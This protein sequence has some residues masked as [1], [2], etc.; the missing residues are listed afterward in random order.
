MA[1]SAVIG[2]LRVDLGIDSAKFSSGLER[3]RGNLINF[4]SANDNLARSL[5]IS[6]RA[7]TTMRLAAVGVA[8]AVGAVLVAATRKFAAETGE[9][10]KVQAQLAARLASTGAVAGQTIDSLN[11]NA[12][13]LQKITTYGDEAIGTSQALLLTFTN[14]RGPVFERATKAILDM[15]T[16]LEQDLKSSTIQLGKAL[17]DPIKGITALTKVGVTFTDAQKTMVESMVEAGET[18]KAQALILKEIE[19]QMGGAA[20]AARNT[21]PGA[22]DAL[23]NSWGNVFE[24]ADDKTSK[25]TDTIN[26][27]TE[28]I[29]SPA[30]IEFVNIIGVTLVG[31]LAKAVEWA[32]KLFNALSAIPGAL[33]DAG[34]A[35]ANLPGSKAISGFLNGSNSFKNRE[36]KDLD[37]YI[38][39]SQGRLAKARAGGNSRSVLL[40]ERELN[41][42]LAERKK[43]TDMIAGAGSLSSVGKVP[44][45]G[46]ILTTGMPSFSGGIA[47]TGLNKGSGSRVV[48]DASEDIQEIASESLEVLTSV[49]NELKQ[50]FGSDV[51]NSWFWNPDGL[52]GEL[53]G[54]TSGFEE[55]GDS[56]K[57]AADIISNGL[58]RAIT[59]G[60]GFK[61]TLISI[62]KELLAL[63]FRKSVL[64]PMSNGLSSLIGSALGSFGGFRAAGGPVSAGSAYVVGERGPELFMPRSNGQI[65]PN[66]GGGVHVTVGVSADNNGNILPF[67]ESVT[68]RSLTRA[69]PQIVAASVRQVDRNFGSMSVKAQRQ[70]L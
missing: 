59:S 14:I 49:G 8:V 12:S 17:N 13:A 40:E 33:R 68:Q 7:L 18:G 22:L 32:V 28:I 44:Q 24:V 37:R 67:V 51:A 34:N 63:S 66:G 42:L 55:I 65:V 29:Q 11:K 56:A 50:D 43:I 26:G 1:N 2:A 31:A 54:L 4:K 5:G 46:N 58:E 3:A 52:G 45:I 21:L 25:L 9:A 23:K 10:Q 35:I 16:A 62:G 36:V 48:K 64:E 61:E 38:A 57:E 69:A 19:T 47:G 39:S 27:L 15:S 30:F 60:D 6:S 53:E 20:E 41:R 70:Q